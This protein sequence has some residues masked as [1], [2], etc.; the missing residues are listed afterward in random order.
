[1][2][3][4]TPYT[5]DRRY[6]TRQLQQSSIKQRFCHRPSLCFH[7]SFL[8]GAKNSLQIFYGTYTTPYA[9]CFLAVV[10]NPKQA[11]SSIKNP[12]SSVICQLAFINEVGVKVPQHLLTPFLNELKHN[13]PQATLHQSNQTNDKQVK[14]LLNN[15][16]TTKK[17]KEKTEET[18]HVLAQ[19][20]PLQLQV[21]QAVACLPSGSVASYSQ[22]AAYVQ[23]P[24][25]VR[26]VAS[27]V[28]RNPV[29]Y[30]IPCHRIIKNDGQVHAY[31]WSS[32]LKL[33]MLHAEAQNKLR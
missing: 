31:R 27:A 12:N 26:A 16:F 30:L 33:A 5:Y 7:Q 9:T 8:E 13:W 6:F 21:W 20:T 29:A 15:I 14:K 17:G 18:W 2:L 25:A 23:K 24:L 11:L 28:A 4:S 32:T 10:A 22:L 19:A 3:L 1:M